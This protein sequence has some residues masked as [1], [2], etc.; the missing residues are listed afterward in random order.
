MM[1][2]FFTKEET[3]S[4]ERP[5]GKTYSCVSCGRYKN[6]T[7]PKMQ[8]FGENRLGI[9]CVGNFPTKD[10]EH[11][12]QNSDGHYLRLV[13]AKIGINLFE[14]CLNVN[15]VRC[16]DAELPTEFQTSC[17][18]KLLLHTQRSAQPKVIILFGIDAIRSVIGKRWKG[19]IGSIEKWRGLII[20]DQDLKAWVCPV[21]NPKDVNANEKK[22]ME[23]IWMQDLKKALA[24]VKVPFQ[25]DK[26]FE[27]DYIEDLSVLNKIKSEIVS[28]D[29]ETTGIKP[30]AKG[31]RIVCA[32]VADSADHV[33]TF[34]MPETRQERQP[35]I[36]LLTRDNIGKM[37][38]NCLHGRSL[39]LMA[40]GKKQR[41][42][43]LVNNKISD[44]VISYNE[45][46]KEVEFKPIINW[47][48]QI[49]ENVKWKKII[50]E[51]SIGKQGHGLTPEHKVYIKDKGMIPVDSVQ[52]GDMLLI[53]KKG[54][55]EVQKQIIL[56]SALG[57]GN[58]SVQKNVK[59]KNPKFQV[60]HSPRQKE[61]L[62]WKH[63]LLFNISSKITI[64]KNE[65]GFGKIGNILHQ[66]YTKSLPDLL[67]I[68]KELYF[69]GKKRITE[70]YLDQLDGLGFAVWFMDDGSLTHSKTSEIIR[71]HTAGFSDESIQVFIKFM[72]KKYNI[73]FKKQKLKK[74]EGGYLTLAMK[75]GGIKF[76][77]L[78]AKYIQPELMYKIPKY[79]I[80]RNGKTSMKLNNQLVNTCFSKII[81]IV[82]VKPSVF[83]FNRYCLEV[84][85]NNNFFTTTGLVSNCKFE[86]TWTL[87][88][89]RAEVNYWE[90]DSMIAAH[91]IDNRQGFTGLKFQTYINFGVVDYASEVAPYLESGSKDGNAFNRI[92]ELVQTEQGMHKLLT[93]CAMDS[94]YQFRL[95]QLQFPKI[96]YNFLPF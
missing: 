38:H 78:I 69:D 85:D 73:L 95:A 25:K 14:D 22:E 13:F 82:D 11:A 75:S 52:I 34:M 66:F 71:L 36:N 79:Y 64:I 87:V 7:V 41:I 30:H 91:I 67:P 32:S 90:W 55:S 68:Y 65:R 93:Y 63:E 77:D 62:K 89:L 80:K 81:G 15:A 4:V 10:E 9:L 3:Q 47:Y 59:A 83:K 19:D 27:I 40:D 6:S 44:K 94:I 2:G 58:L 50:T 16:Y 56:G 18:R 76:F 23:V 51:N 8:P 49:D 28:F 33:F 37:A 31:H 42:S 45:K 61:Y 21:Y 12:F 74:H 54:L 24:M 5:D 86:D 35:F 70:T 92:L 17:C 20:P 39:I 53:Y 88:R 60:S 26:P 57:D 46:T 1:Q 48:K 43:Y 29:Y 96:G 84:D 72:Y